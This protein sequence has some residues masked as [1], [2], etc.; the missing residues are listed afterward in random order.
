[1]ENKIEMRI[2]KK[3]KKELTLEN[4]FYKI[5]GKYRNNTCKKCISIKNK[6]GTKF[7]KL[8]EKTKNNI[9]KLLILKV[10]YSEICRQNDI[11]YDTLYSW[12]RKKKFIINHN[13]ICEKES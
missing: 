5:R 3:C 11:K 7:D 12:I 1:M 4:N 6:I 13:Q 2:C 9:I 8:D 10:P